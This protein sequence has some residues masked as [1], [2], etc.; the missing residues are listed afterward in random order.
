MREP[1][2]QVYVKLDEGTVNVALRAWA[3]T[4]EYFSAFSVLTD[5]IKSEL[6]DIDI[7]QIRVNIKESEVIVRTIAHWQHRWEEPLL[8]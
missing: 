5:A 4:E 1:A 6:A 2:P 7:Q 3:K 8:L